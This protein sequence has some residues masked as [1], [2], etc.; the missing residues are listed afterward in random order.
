MQYDVYAIG[1]ALV[2]SEFQVEDSF[3]RE[4]NIEK[5]LITLVDQER[6]DALE[7]A[8]TERSELQA[9]NCGGSAGNTLFALSV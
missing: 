5:G 2:D 9:R 1:N 8:L 7:K 6:L 3:L 4:N